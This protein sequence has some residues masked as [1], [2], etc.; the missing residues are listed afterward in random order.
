MR[1]M[2]GFVPLRRARARAK[3]FRQGEIRRPVEPGVSREHDCNAGEELR[4]AEPFPELGIWGEMGAQIDESFF[5]IPIRG[6]PRQADSAQPKSGRRRQQQLHERLFALEAEDDTVGSRPAAQ[7]TRR[8]QAIELPLQ[9]RQGKTRSARELAQMNAR[10]GTGAERLEQAAASRAE[11][12]VKRVPCV[13]HD[14]NVPIIGTFFKAMDP[15]SAFDV[16]RSPQ[17]S[18]QYSRSRAAGCP[19]GSAPPRP[20][21]P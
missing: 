19:P 9:R 21:R 18:P 6:H 15:R 8:G 10:L 16:R 1:P 11:Q 17:S 3:R 4:I 20:P 14:R 13:I 12:L 5:R 2:P 7:D